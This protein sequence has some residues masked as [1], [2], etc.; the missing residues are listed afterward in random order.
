MIIK[1][2]EPN[3]RIQVSNSIEAAISAFGIKNPNNGS[4]VAQQI[5]DWAYKIL[6]T[7]TWP[8]EY[9]KIEHVVVGLGVLFGHALATDYNWE[10]KS[11]IN[12]DIKELSIVAPREKAYVPVMTYMY[13]ILKG[14]KEV[15]VMLL[16]NM[17]KN[18]DKNLPKTKS[19]ARLG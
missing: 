1:D 8:E 6:E 19:T 3:M 4:E 7:R 13:Q 12:D 5:D 18:P 17:L 14:M 10:W 2:L 11:V 9:E 16:Y 15:N